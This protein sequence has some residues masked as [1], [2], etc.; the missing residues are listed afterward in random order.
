MPSGKR[1]TE[2]KGNAP[3]NTGPLKNSDGRTYNLVEEL[4]ELAR[5]SGPLQRHLFR[6]ER[7]RPRRR[8]PI[9]AVW[10]PTVADGG[11]PQARG[12]RDPVRPLYIFGYE[13][14]P[15]LLSVELVEK[16]LHHTVHS[17]LPDERTSGKLYLSIAGVQ[18]PT[19]VL[20]FG[21][22]SR[23]RQASPNGYP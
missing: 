20:T 16:N 17:P 19:T 10:C 22:L 23:I 14:A 12:H 3:V 4:N 2:R 7:H 13:R 6:P 11:A 9:G 8:D 5:G 1:E 15:T 21:P 18:N